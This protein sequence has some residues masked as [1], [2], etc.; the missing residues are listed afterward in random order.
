MIYKIK[1]NLKIYYKKKYNDI[2]IN[3]N[4]DLFFGIINNK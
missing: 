4:N 3:N 2:I 1:Y